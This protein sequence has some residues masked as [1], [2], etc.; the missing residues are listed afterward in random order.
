M[1]FAAAQPWTQVMLAEV[2]HYLARVGEA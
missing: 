1:R 2:P